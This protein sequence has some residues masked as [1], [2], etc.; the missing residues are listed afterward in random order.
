MYKDT[1]ARSDIKTQKTAT[2]DILGQQLY[3]G[4]QARALV[5]LKVAKHKQK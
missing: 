2:I 5:A 3:Y 4:S 1:Q